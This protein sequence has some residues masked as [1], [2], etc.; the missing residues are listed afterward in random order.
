MTG[1][2]AS[3]SLILLF[4]VRIEFAA[5]LSWGVFP[6][7]PVFLPPQKPTFLNFHSNGNITDE[8]QPS[9]FDTVIVVIIAVIIQLLSSFVIIIIK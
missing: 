7:S 2:S 5:D 6:C 4:A 9:E 3:V 8:E 1:S